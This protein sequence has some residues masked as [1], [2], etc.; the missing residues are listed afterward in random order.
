MALKFFCE[1]P[2]CPGFRKTIAG[3]KVQYVLREGKLVPS[4]TPNCKDCG[5]PLA[6]IEE[7][8]STVPNINIGEFN[9][10]SAEQKADI[11]KKRHQE[12]TMSSNTKEEAKFHADNTLKRFFG[13]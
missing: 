2:D 13:N 1:N 3:H 7:R 6:L 4:R 12:H 10:M 8:N 5:E 11:L 9:G